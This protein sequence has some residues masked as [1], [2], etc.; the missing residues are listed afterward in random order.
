MACSLRDDKRTAIH[1]QVGRG[2]YHGISNA[3]G[4]GGRALT[5]KRTLFLLPSPITSR[6]HPLDT[7]IGQA[8]ILPRP[9]PGKVWHLPLEELLKYLRTKV[10]L[11]GVLIR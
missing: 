2:V 3:G 5:T 8:S 7:S 9:L 10:E 1:S 6:R 11:G 4:K